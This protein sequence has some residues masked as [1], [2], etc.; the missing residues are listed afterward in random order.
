MPAN[1]AGGVT[2]S[3]HNLQF[4]DNSCG[5]GMTVANPHLGPLQDNGGVRVGVGLVALQTRLPLP[6]S[7]ALNAA[8]NAACPTRDERGFLRLVPCDIGAV[9][10]VFPLLLPLLVR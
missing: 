8:D 10:R 2:D 5:A 6:G 7:P 9:E 3:G 4:G 1:C